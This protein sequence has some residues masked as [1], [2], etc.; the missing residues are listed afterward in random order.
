M[1]KKL[2]KN[3]EKRHKEEQKRQQEA[4]KARIKSF[5][6]IKI[7]LPKAPLNKI[8]KTILRHNCDTYYY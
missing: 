8:K 4:D 5:K 7:M 2:Q 3:I 6:N 1:N